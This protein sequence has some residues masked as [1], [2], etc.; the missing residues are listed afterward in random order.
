MFHDVRY[1]VIFDI[2]TPYWSNSSNKYFK[3]YYDTPFL[4][5]C[6]AECENA[7]GTEGGSCADGFGMYFKNWCSK[8]CNQQIFSYGLF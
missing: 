5:W 6:S 3:T 2:T 7:G 4:F 1:L 8:F